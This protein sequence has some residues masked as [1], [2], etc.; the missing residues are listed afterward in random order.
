MRLKE[1][2]RVAFLGALLVLTGCNTLEKADRETD[3]LLNRVSNPGPSSSGSGLSVVQRSDMTVRTAKDAQGRAVAIWGQ[4]RS[5]ST[6]PGHD[7]TMEAKALSM[8]LSGDYEYITIQRSWRT[9]TGRV[10]KSRRIPDIIG[11]RRSGRVDA[12]E[13]ES[14]TDKRKDLRQRL[15]EGMQTLP[16]KRRGNYD[17]LEPRL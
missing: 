8:A 10:S 15:R 4:T 6:T 12:Y 5:S 7:K 16:A 1:I 17:I 3:R 9:A 11:V 14:K 13:V 2:I